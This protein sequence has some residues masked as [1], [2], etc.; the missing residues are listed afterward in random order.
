MG[1]SRARQTDIA[2]A[3]RQ[4]RA[5][6]RPQTICEHVSL[7]RGGPSRCTFSGAKQGPS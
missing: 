6:E 3:T 7:T 1:R 2:I 5:H 4:G